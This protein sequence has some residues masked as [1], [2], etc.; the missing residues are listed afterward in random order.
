MYKKHMYNMISSL[1]FIIN[2]TK[3]R[4]CKCMLQTI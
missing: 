4:W 3:V 1:V 2:S